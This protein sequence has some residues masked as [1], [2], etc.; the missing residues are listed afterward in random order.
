MSLLTTLLWKAALNFTGD[1]V[2]RYEVDTKGSQ[3][4]LLTTVFVNYYQKCR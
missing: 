3:A 4:A 1:Y 2:L